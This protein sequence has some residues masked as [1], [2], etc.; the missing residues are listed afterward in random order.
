MI[1]TQLLTSPSSIRIVIITSVV[2]AATASAISSKFG[3]FS[4]IGGIIGTS[5][6]ASFL[7][8]LGIMNTYILYKLLQ[9]MRKLIDSTPGEEQSFEIKGAGCLF[10]LFKKMFKLIDRWDRFLLAL[11]Y[12][13]SG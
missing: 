10:Y 1:V 4:K 3:A 12:E 5:I 9:L 6:S 13:T 8:I 7:I 2:V 11:R